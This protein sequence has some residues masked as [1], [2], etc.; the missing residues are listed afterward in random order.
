M[1]GFEGQLGGLETPLPRFHAL[2]KGCKGLR[3]TLEFFEDVLGP[4]A[5]PL[6]KKVKALQDHLGDLQDAVVTSGVLRD[7]LTWGTWRHGGHDLPG[8]VEVIVA[9]GAARYLAA[10]QEEMERLIRTLP[11]RVADARRQR[12]QP[13]A[14]DGDRRD[15]KAGS[16]VDGR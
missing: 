12:L 13:G 14:G 7:Y 6:I 4:G 1:W 2:R 15:L 8:P 9:P 3:Y 11:G 16:V 10:R 5:R